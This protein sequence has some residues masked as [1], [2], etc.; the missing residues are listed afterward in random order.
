MNYRSAIPHN[1]SHAVPVNAREMITCIERVSLIVSEKLK[2]PVR[3]TFDGPVVKM[4]CIT[5]V[6]KSY[7]ECAL[8]ESVEGLEIGI[9]QSVFA[10]RFACMRR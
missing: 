8:G 4:S 5:A 1:F 7:D 3:M 2:N 10:G 9:Q 6:G